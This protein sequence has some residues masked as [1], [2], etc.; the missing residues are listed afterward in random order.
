MI[1]AHGRILWHKLVNFYGGDT[2]FMYTIGNRQR[3]I[4]STKNK[5]IINCIFPFCRCWYHGFWQLLAH[6]SGILRFGHPAMAALPL[7]IQNSKRQTCKPI[8]QETHAR[9]LLLRPN[10]GETRWRTCLRLFCSC[11]RLCCSIRSSR[12]WWHGSITKRSTSRLPVMT[13]GIKFCFW[14][15]RLW[16]IVIASNSFY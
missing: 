13:S 10:F 12:V 3:S 7:Q 2:R 6:R 8:D 15:V 1:A 5:Y 11:F 9:E 14:I 4:S 16:Q